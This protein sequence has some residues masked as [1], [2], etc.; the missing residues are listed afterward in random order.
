MK[1]ALEQD[2][3]SALAARSVVEIP[4][5][6]TGKSYVDLAVGAT[7]SAGSLY[8][9]V[10]DVDPALSNMQLSCRVLLHMRAN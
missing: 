7:I 8:K 4:V 3:N 10:V 6:A 9:L 1:L 2:S 5:Q